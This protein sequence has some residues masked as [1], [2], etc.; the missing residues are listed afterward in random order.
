[1][2]EKMFVYIIMCD[3]SK[4][5]CLS[6][7]LTESMAN[8]NYPELLKL[9]PRNHRAWEVRDVVILIIFIY[10]LLQINII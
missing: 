9:A 4:N 2:L 3:D 1:M 6:N 5:I 7:L 10:Y 8:P